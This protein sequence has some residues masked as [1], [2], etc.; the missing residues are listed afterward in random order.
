MT[1]KERLVPLGK[2]YA[3]YKLRVGRGSTF[4]AELEGIQN[5]L[6]KG[7]VIIL[8]INSYTGWLPPIWILP[9]AW[10]IQKAFEYFAG[11]YDQEHLGW[12]KYEQEYMSKNIDP[13]KQDVDKKLAEII[14]KLK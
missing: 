10:A 8:L 11:K 3:V 1:W 6:T 12:W 13:W 14:S 7:G 5:A 9:I 2:A 4:T